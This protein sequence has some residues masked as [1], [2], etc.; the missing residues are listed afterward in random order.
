MAVACLN[1]IKIDIEELE[2]EMLS[3]AEKIIF[4]S[5]EEEGIIKTYD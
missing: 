4:K 1:I 5:L 2:Y 3:G